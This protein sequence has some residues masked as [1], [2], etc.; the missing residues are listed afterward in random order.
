VLRASHTISSVIYLCVYQKCQS[1][2]RAPGWRTV[3]GTGLL[4]RGDMKMVVVA[5]WPGPAGGLW[6]SGVKQSGAI[7]YAVS[8][9]AAGGGAGLLDAVTV[10]SLKCTHACTHTHP[11]W[12][13]AVCHLF[14]YLIFSFCL[15]FW[16]TEH[17]VSEFGDFWNWCVVPQPMCQCL[18]E[19]WTFSLLLNVLSNTFADYYNSN[20]TGWQW[21]VPL[22]GNRKVAGS[23]PQLLPPSSRCPSARQLTLTAPD[24]LTVALRGWH[25]HHF[26]NVCVNVRRCKVLYKCNP[27]TK[28]HLMLNHWEYG[29]KISL[30]LINLFTHSWC[31]LLRTMVVVTFEA[32]SCHH[33]SSKCV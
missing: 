3:C 28:W 7:C 16:V 22:S 8:G 2:P 29:K 12:S 27:F 14:I 17:I 5:V 24:Q 31:R 25:R 1:L 21:L 10:A 4:T 32:K 11:R 23:I 33:I 19:Y 30:I 9:G 18:P 6:I 13:F 26:M 20:C 15:G